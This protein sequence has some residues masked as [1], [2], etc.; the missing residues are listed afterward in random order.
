MAIKTVFPYSVSSNTSLPSTIL[1]KHLT[2]KYLSLKA[3]R[4]FGGVFS[5]NQIH[6]V[7]ILVSLVLTSQLLSPVFIRLSLTG[8]YRN[9]QASGW[10]RLLS[11]HYGTAIYRLS[12]TTPPLN[13]TRTLLICT[14]LSSP[15]I[16]KLCKILEPISPRNFNYSE[17]PLSHML[18]GQFTSLSW[19]SCHY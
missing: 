10:T 6:L 14:Y 12:T 16:S 1:V 9:C 8:D 3:F 17:I 18:E 19:W 15:G 4:H 13:F 7:R 2:C 11:L 5:A